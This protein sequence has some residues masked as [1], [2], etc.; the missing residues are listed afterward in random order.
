MAYY[1]SEIDEKILDFMKDNLAEL[2]EQIDSDSGK[3]VYYT[4]GVRLELTFGVPDPSRR[5][6]IG[7]SKND[8]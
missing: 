6:V 2:I 1:F 7:E 8:N 5:L 4:A 3:S